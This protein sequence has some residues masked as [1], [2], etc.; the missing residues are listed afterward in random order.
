MRKILT[1]LVA[2]AT[3]SATAIATS[4]KADAWW[5]WWVLAQWPAEL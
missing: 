3:I 5:G 2:A 1:A 4:R